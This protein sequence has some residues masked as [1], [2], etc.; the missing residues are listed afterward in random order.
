MSASVPVN[1]FLRDGALRC[2]IAPALG[3]CIAG[4]WC[5]GVPV[6]R[7][8]PAVDLQTVRLSGSY[9]L[10]PYSNRLGYRRLTPH[11]APLSLP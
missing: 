1:L 6:L 10:V 9:P 3:G 5:G 8:T 2:D 7:S 4:L 11:L